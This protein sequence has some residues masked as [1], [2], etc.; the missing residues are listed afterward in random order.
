[1][2]KNTGSTGGYFSRNR[3]HPTDHLQLFFTSPK[4]QH[5]QQ[6]SQQNHLQS[7]EKNMHLDINQTSGQSA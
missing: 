3:L 6:L 5:Q 2:G 7:L 4:K 1:V